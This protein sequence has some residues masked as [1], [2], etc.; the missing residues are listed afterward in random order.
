MEFEKITPEYLRRIWID[1]KES[2]IIIPIDYLNLTNLEPTYFD[3]P[4]ELA[5]S[6]IALLEK[7]FVEIIYHSSNDLNGR[8][9]RFALYVYAAGGR[10]LYKNESYNKF[11][12]HITWDN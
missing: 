11:S 4:K 10:I 1:K 3:V 9:I 5:P 7:N 8:W 2:T 12:A 6:P